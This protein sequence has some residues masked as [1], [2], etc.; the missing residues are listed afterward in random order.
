MR[1]C[2][3][4]GSSRPEHQAL[5]LGPTGLRRG[6]PVGL[7]CREG[8]GDGVGGCTQPSARESRLSGDAALLP[9][10][11]APPLQREDQ[12]GCGNRWALDLLSTCASSSP[13]LSHTAHPRVGQMGDTREARAP[14]PRC[15]CPSAQG[16][17][18]GHTLILIWQLAALVQ[19]STWAVRRWRIQPEKAVGILGVTA[20]HRG[21]P[22]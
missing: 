2:R 19:I 3:A 7:P 13:G 17:K 1:G 10:S 8:A 16:G 15:V 12:K 9:P 5:R 20:A 4:P 6:E 21:H 18:K 22:L 14:S 11:L